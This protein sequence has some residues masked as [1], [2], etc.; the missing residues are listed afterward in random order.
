M[1]RSGAG[2]SIQDEPQVVYAEC[3]HLWRGSSCCLCLWKGNLVRKSN[4]G[5]R[6][7]AHSTVLGRRLLCVDRQLLFLI[8]P[9][10]LAKGETRVELIFA[11]SSP[12]KHQARIC[13]P[14]NKSSKK[15]CITLPARLEKSLGFFTS[16]CSPA[17][18]LLP[19]QA[20]VPEARRVK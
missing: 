18:M 2:G 15:R 7:A 4:Q 3:C 13:R 9:G 16:R 14:K 1:Q 5:G 11:S 10:N 8:V 12:V 17:L 6:R 19:L 20:Q